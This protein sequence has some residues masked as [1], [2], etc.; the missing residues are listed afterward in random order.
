MIWGLQCENQMPTVVHIFRCLRHRLPMKPVE[1]VRAI[2]DTGLDGCAHGRTG[3]P[4]QVLLV[5]VETLDEFS[6]VPG[7]VKEN[8]TTR[9][10]DVRGLARGQRLRIG[11]A[12]LE[13]TLPCE[14]CGRMDDI[15]RGLQQDLRGKRGKLC[16]VVASGLIRRGDPIELL[17][18]EQAST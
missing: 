12:V 3:S 10:L 4:R 14:P 17:P 15:R 11:E 1:E 2:Q 6:L 7:A 18:L 9:G 5:D 16:R 13:V 8:I